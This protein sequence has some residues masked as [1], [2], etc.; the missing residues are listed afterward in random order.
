MDGEKIQIIK[1]VI[2]RRRQLCGNIILLLEE[3][4]RKE[5]NKNRR[6]LRSRE[7]LKRRN[8]GQGVLTMLFDELKPEDPRS[9]KNYTRM[10]EETMERLLHQ[11]APL[12]QK[13]DTVMREAISARMRLSVTLRYLATGNSFQDLAFSTRIAPNILSQ[14]IP[15]ML[16]AIINVLQDNVLQFPNKSK[17]W[18]IISAQFQNLWQFRHCIGSFD[19]KHICFRPPRLEGSKYRNYKGTDS[20]ILSGLVD[21][22]Y[23]F[24]FVDIG[25]NGRLHDSTVF[26]E[27]PLGI[28]MKKN[29]LNLPE[30]NTLPGLNYK[31]SYVFVGDN[32]F[33]LHQNLMK[34]YPDRELTLERRILNYR[35]SRARRVVENP[36]VF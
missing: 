24:I 17:D 11:I 10:A 13:K 33:T 25:K 26:R 3:L 16:D 12:I 35:L 28:K 30:P 4:K 22:N 32:A 36:L 7:W 5:E 6:R 15:E 20:I 9:F 14:I 21:A 27:S 1:C 31:L 34:P 23:K 2:G 8:F 18:S 19:G 29:A